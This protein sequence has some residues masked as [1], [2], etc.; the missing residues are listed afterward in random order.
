LYFGELIVGHVRKESIESNPCMQ[1]G[2]QTIGS[3][4]RAIRDRL[5]GASHVEHADYAVKPPDGQR[6]FLTHDFPK[7]ALDRSFARGTRHT[8]STRTTGI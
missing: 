6:H 2:V 4:L 8:A 1:S 3:H 7:D 5:V